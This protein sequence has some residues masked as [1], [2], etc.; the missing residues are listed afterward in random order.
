MSD[1]VEPIGLF[2][3][4]GGAESVPVPAKTRDKPPAAEAKAEDQASPSQGTAPAK[5]DPPLGLNQSAAA[6]KI[7]IDPG[8]LRTITEVLDRE[9]GEVMFSIPI[10]YRSESGGVQSTGGGQR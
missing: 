9:S 1:I 4:R 7:S 8:T 2:P 10:G 3:S 5:L 6:Y